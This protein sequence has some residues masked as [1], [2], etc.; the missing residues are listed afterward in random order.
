MRAITAGV[1]VV[2]FVGLIL[3]VRSCAIVP[4]GHVTVLDIFGSV[5]SQELY[6]GLQ[7]ANPFARRIEME[8]R[9][10]QKEEQLAVPTKEGLIAGLD[11]SILYKINPTKA[12]EI[13]KTL[14]VHYE[15][16]FMIPTLRNVGRDV[17]ASYSSEDL[18]SV[19]RGKMASDIMEKMT[20]ACSPRGI[21]VESIL[22]RDVKLPDQVKDAIE[23][24]I[25][26]K[27]QAEQME[28]VL[29]KEKQ[30]AERKKIEANGLS[31]AQKI[32]SG[33]LTEEYL[34]WKYITSLES[35]AHSQN[36]TFVIAPYD[37][38]LIPLLPLTS[39]ENTETKTTKK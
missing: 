2:V 35:L 28:Y 15:N 23:K 10:M 7:T 33:S 32:I 12:A 18:Y 22:L 26:A 31:D 20:S 25:A 21:T 36:T 9:T 29:Q 17:V 27:Q 16:V 19:N 38:K 11:I 30:E 8:T 3:G 4:A 14:G 34:Q 5:K 6:P 13:Y 24:K 37:Q 1:A 39:K